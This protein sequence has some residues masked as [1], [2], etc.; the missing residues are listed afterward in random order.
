MHPDRSEILARI[1][2][3]IIVSVQAENNEPLGRPELL[4]AMAKAAVL[5]GAVGI[6]VCYPENI[7]A[8]RQAVDV[9]IIG[10]YKKQ[11]PD[12][13]VIISPRWEDNWAVVQ[14]GPEIVALD[15][16]FRQRPE[17]QK[18]KSIYRKLRENSNALLMAD[19]STFKEGIAAAE[20]GFD[21]VGTTLSGYTEMT[22]SIDEYTPDFKLLDQLCREIG[23]RIPVIAEGRIWEPEQV[24]R[25]M[26]LGAY[27]VVIG[28]AITRPWLITQ[29][30]VQALKK[31]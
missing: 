12:S 6:R 1:K 11:Y 14:S 18:L 20:M 28:S 16:T 27:A 31:S 4:A 22:P 24:R 29:R 30:F 3:G 9:P 8:I 2:G 17:G 23:D 7:L 5:G 19:I 25:A 10:I 26:T 13:E 21:L 15:A